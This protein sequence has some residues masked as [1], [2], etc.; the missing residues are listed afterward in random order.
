MHTGGSIN[1]DEI[2]KFDA[3]AARWW[4]ATG[5]MR[6]LHMMNPV[7]AAWILDRIA[8]HFRG[9]LQSPPPVMPTVIPAKAGTGIHD[10]N[11]LRI[12][13]V[14]CGA[15]L[16][17]ESLAKA[18]YNVLGLDAAGEAITAARAHAAGR[19]L[20]LEYRAGSA[21][22]L[23]A[24]GA[25]FPIIT[26]LEIIEHVD[27]PAGFIATLASLLEPGGLLFISTLN[28]TPRSWLTAKL[29]AEFLFR[30][31]P[32]GTH[33]WKQ[34][35]P[36]AELDEYFRRADLRLA[37]IAGMGF[38]PRRGFRITRDTSVNYIAVAAAP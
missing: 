7:R 29:G 34:F 12:L 24:E 17:S 8:K 38:D 14:G 3:L 21:E 23:V 35:V 1:P 9:S 25:K 16:L 5:P 18:G 28:R 19:N 2:K 32:V 26:A 15:G 11:P 20:R 31:L 30:L 6:P 22:D 10:L 33:D 4:D 13:D 37:A 27:D 36:P